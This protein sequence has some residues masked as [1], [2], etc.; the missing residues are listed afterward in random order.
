MSRPCFALVLVFCA[1]TSFA[2]QSADEKSV[3]NLEHSYWEYV[4]ALDLKSYRDLW[5]TNFV[6][7]PSVSAQPVRK[8]HITDWITANTSK[9]LHLKSYNLEPASSQETGNIV[10]DYYWLTMVWADKDGHGDPRTIRVTHTWIKDD[11]G[12]RIV[13]GMSAA[14]L[15]ARK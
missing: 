5:H 15:E 12:W 3:W 9:G 7:W 4:K 1:L 10:V 13:G 2:Q 11:Q 6:G 14:E 8:D